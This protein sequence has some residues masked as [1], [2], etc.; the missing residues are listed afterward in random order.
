MFLPHDVTD[1]HLLGDLHG[2]YDRHDR[3]AK[4]HQFTIQMGD[5]GFEYGSLVKHDPAYHKVLGGNHDNYDL[6]PAMPHY[7]GDYGIFEFSTLK[8][9]YMRGAYSIDLLLRTIGID[10]WEQE[11]LTIKQLNSALEYYK[12]S[13]PDIIISH[14]P[15]SF[16]VPCFK[17][18]NIISSNTEECLEAMHEAHRPRLHFFAHMHQQKTIKR[19]DTRSICVATN[20]VVSLKKYLQ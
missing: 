19:H 14:A 6:L 15:P 1:I 10:W 16:A 12:Q 11:Q 17:C 7:L 5:F 4:K 9:F 8:I 20:Q 13:K 2:A 18:I 3:V